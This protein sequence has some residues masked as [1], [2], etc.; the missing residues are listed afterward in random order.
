MNPSSFAAGC[1]LND[2]MIPQSIQGPLVDGRD[3]VDYHWFR[4]SISPNGG[5]VIL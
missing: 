4:E 5:N 3:Q 2:A 1:F